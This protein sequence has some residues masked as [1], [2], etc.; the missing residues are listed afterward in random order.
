MQ[1]HQILLDDFPF[2]NMIEVPAI[3]NY[4]GIVV[5]WDDNLLEVDEI[6]ITAQELHVMVKVS[7]TNTSRLFSC[8]Y[9]STNRSMRKILCKNIISIKHN[10]SGKWLID[11]DLN[12]LLHNSGKK[13]ENPLSFQLNI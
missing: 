6:A 9:A 11:G 4:G 1:D 10:Y 3:G 12:E 13:G 7:S 5:L 8:I 2:K